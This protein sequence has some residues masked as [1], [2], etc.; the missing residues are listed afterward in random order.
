[1]KVF[2]FVL[3]LFFLQN[4]AFC[5]G[6]FSKVGSYFNDFVDAVKKDFTPSDEAEKKNQEMVQKLKEEL[7]EDVEK[8]AY[9][10]RGDLYEKYL[11]FAQDR[12]VSDDFVDAYYFKQKANKIR[13][14]K[15]I[16]PSNPLSFG[17]LPDDL[18]QF[19][20]G[21]KRLIELS[22]KNI[23][24]SQY[25][26]VLADSYI[27]YDCW[28]E[29][30]EN[31]NNVEKAQRCRNRFIDNVKSLEVVLFDNGVPINES[32]VSFNKKYHKCKT[33]GM[34]KK[35]YFCNA[36]YFNEKSPVLLDKMNIV[37]KKIQ[38]RSYTM[39]TASLVVMYNKVG[40]GGLDLQ[41]LRLD[42]VSNI[43]YNH[44]IAKSY[45]QPVVRFVEVQKVSE[46]KFFEDSVVVCA[47]DGE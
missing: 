4:D 1:M 19:L 3:S 10:F 23:V 42:A 45:V 2:I 13:N 27:A 33:C 22:I 11:R 18:E 43:I 46:G 41:K 28:L 44:V 39:P 29:A 9:D 25:G 5:E 40:K 38:Q 6:I 15:I 26:R 20:D 24:E 7:S 32:I 14:Y 35:G 17:I 47:V 16:S 36:L 8:K 30:F 37:I 31:G 21:R 12:Y 34:N